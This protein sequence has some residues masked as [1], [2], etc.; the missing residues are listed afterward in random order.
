MSPR[1]V[2]VRLTSR[3]RSRLP[4]AARELWLQPFMPEVNGRAPILASGPK[5]TPVSTPRPGEVAWCAASIGCPSG[6]P[7]RGPAVTM[8]WN[9]RFQI[10]AVPTRCNGPIQF[11]GVPTRCNGRD[12]A[13]HGRSTS[14]HLTIRCMAPF[15][16]T[17]WRCAAWSIS[18]RS[19]DDALYG[20]FQ[21]TKNAPWR[22]RSPRA[23]APAPCR[24]SWCA[25]PP[26]ARPSAPRTRRP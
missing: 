24:R 4:D 23:R 7:Q 8:R 16:F 22:R 18:I 11:A 20:R 26:N 21:V 15:H 6:C 14:Q 2:D 5:T 19:R 3:D 17:A 25:T 10:A 1:K 12:D 13:L 9:G